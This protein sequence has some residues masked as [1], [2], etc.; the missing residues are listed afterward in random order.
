MS[1]LRTN[2]IP[3][4]RAGYARISNGITCACAIGLNPSGVAGAQIRLKNLG[5][6]QGAGK[7][8]ID[9]ETRTA[10]S[11]FQTDHEIEPT[12]QLDEATKAAL[13]DRHGS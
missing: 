12:G 8:E 10:L 3:S 5:Y 9:S 6:Y 7:G 2:I 4:A 11:R 1:L 13:V